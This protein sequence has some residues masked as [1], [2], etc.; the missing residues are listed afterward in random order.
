MS[1]GTLTL[2][3]TKLNSAVSR[4]FEK[5]APNS[6]TCSL[7]VAASGGLP[8]VSGTGLYS[9]ASGSAHITVTVGFILPRNDGKCDTANNVTPTASQQI[10]YGTGTVSFG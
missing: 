9:G 2:D 6:S 8:F 1:Q 10:V 5:A 4:G 3:K 7:S